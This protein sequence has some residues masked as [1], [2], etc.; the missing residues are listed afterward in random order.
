MINW[1][2]F[3]LWTVTM[4]S[5]FHSFGKHLFSRQFLKWISSGFGTEVVHVFVIQ[6][7]ISSCPLTLLRPNHLITFTISSEKISTFI[8]RLA[9]HYIIMPREYIY[10]TRVQ[11]SCF[12]TGPLNV[13][14]WQ[15]HSWICNSTNKETEL[16][17]SPY[18]QVK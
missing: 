5:L 8:K 18:N 14:F 15:S 11:G 3:F 13:N 7:D 12:V 16:Y 1:L 10:K 2:S 17:F 9:C 4:F 6:I